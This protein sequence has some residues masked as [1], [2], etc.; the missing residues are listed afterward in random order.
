MLAKIKQLR[1]VHLLSR[2]KTVFYPYQ[3]L[4]SDAIINALIQNLS[5]TKSATEE[6]I[7][8][9]EPIEVFAEFSRQCGKT[10]A[11]VLTM[12]FIMVYFPKIF[13]RRIEI[14]VFAPQREQAK[15]DFDRLKDALLRDG[16]LAI[17]SATDEAIFRE[18]S[19][20]TT[21]VL[22]NGASC[23]IFPVSPTT[24]PES[25]SL[26]LI[27]FE[28]SQYLQDQIVKQQIWPMGANTNAPRVYLGTAGTQINYFYREG[29]ANNAIKLYYDEI[30]KQRREVYKETGDATHLIYEQTVKKEIEKYGR[31][32]DEI[33][34]PFFGKWLIGTG[35]FVTTEALDKLE[36]KHRGLTEKYN[37]EPCFAGIDTAKHPDSTVVTVIKGGSE[38]QL[39]NWLEL[40]GENYDTQFEVISGFLARYD[41]KAIAIDSTGQGEFMPDWF[42]RRTN[43][44]DERSGLYRVKFSAQSKDLLF[45]NLK[46]VIEDSLTRLPNISTTV[47]ERS[48]NKQMKFRQQM[49]DLQQEYKGPYLSV[50]H[51]DDPNAH[52]DYP[53]S[54]ALAEWAYA[55]YNQQPTPAVTVVGVGQEKER[56]VK[57]T[58]DNKID[59]YWPGD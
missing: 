31:D 15:T 24:K 34:R 30:V 46:V 50:K 20:A 54:W 28:E 12:D 35:N 48:D 57:K 56:K 4:I 44:K 1:K 14:G 2:H 21:L 55:Q 27:V 47:G 36:D 23:Y 8:K 39:L 41:I 40:K 5:I 38:K 7:Q 10:T 13:K 49:L 19:N 43:W 9:L 26:N 33:A 17:G 25:K 3:E 53:D 18:Q 11:V 58:D 37:K 59:Y 6:E 32:S 42:E 16:P 51:P 22:G 45:K 52:D 29:Q